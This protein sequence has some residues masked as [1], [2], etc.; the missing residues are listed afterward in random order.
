MGKYTFDCAQGY[1]EACM[2]ALQMAEQKKG[3]PPYV[4]EIAAEWSSLVPMT[5]IFHLFVG[6]LDVFRNDEVLADYEC[7]KFTLNPNLQS[8]VGRPSE[9]ELYS[10]RIARVFPTYKLDEKLRVRP[11]PESQTVSFLWLKE[12]L[13]SND[14]ARN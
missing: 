10:D 3:G 4:I 1:R 13:L 14:I 11:G 6:L 12:L 7:N 8:K 9:Y 2:T 5:T